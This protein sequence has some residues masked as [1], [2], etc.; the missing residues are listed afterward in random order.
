MATTYAELLTEIEDEAKRPDLT[1]T[2]PRFVLHAESRLNRDKRLRKMR[3]MESSAD[4][5]INSQEEALPSDFL[6]VR[7][8]YV[9]SDPKTLIHYMEPHVFW[10]SFAG[11]ATGK[12]TAYTIEGSNLV[13]G[14][15]P[16]ATYTGKLS[17]IAKLPALVT[18]STNW[19]LDLHSDIY[20]YASLIALAHH[21]RD[22]KY[23]ATV[24]QMYEA[25]M[26]SLKND[27]RYG[28]SLRYIPKVSP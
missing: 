10:G 3:Q 12:P 24:A 13:F 11:S 2:I 20:L 6:Q 14:K 5:T 23:L 17:Y 21:T 18:N 22:D 9:T 28:G 7:R 25:A 19:L 8:L 16:D 4:I 15:A 1:A 27:D 26:G